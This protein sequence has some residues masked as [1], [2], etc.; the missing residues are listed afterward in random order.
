MIAGPTQGPP[1]RRGP[2]VMHPPAHVLPVGFRRRFSAALVV[3]AVG[4]LAVLIAPN[5]ARPAGPAPGQLRHAC[6]LEHHGDYVV[7]RGEPAPRFAQPPPP[8][9]AGRAY[10]VEIVPLERV[11]AI[12]VD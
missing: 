8:A 1:R 9:A 11:P 4:A 10:T 5:A 2:S 7:R 6:Q 3:A 12:A